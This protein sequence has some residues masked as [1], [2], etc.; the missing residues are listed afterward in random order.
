MT[1]IQNENL[2]ALLFLAKINKLAVSDVISSDVFDVIL[3]K[4]NKSHLISQLYFLVKNDL[5]VKRK[6]LFKKLVRTAI[7]KTSLKISGTG[8]RGSFTKRKEYTQETIEFDIEE[9]LE[10]IIGKQII[11]YDDIVGLYR[12]RM[13][14]RGVLIL[15]TS[16]SMY[17]N[18]ILNAALA[19]A[20]LAYHMREDIYSIIVFSDVATV[21]KKINERVPIVKII[22]S[23]LD[24][25]PVGYTR[26]DDALYKAYNE[27]TK[28]KFSRKWAIIITDGCYNKGEDPSEIAKNFPQLHVIQIPGG[29]SWCNSICKKLANYGKGKLVSV[30]SYKEIPRALIK[31]LR[32]I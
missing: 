5:T 32:T 8:L 31:L 1:A 16:G 24:I 10:N 20:V 12:T 28:V 11:T 6:A 2:N 18:K 3:K 21:I 22:D 27:L 7:L 13:K 29:Q 26:I 17:G 15:D 25:E 19:A 14:K 9:T 30:S 4:F 23:I